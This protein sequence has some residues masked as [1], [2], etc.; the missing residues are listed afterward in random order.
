VDRTIFFPLASKNQIARMFKKFY[1]NEDALAEKFADSIGEARV[2]MAQLQGHFLCA[3][4]DPLKAYSEVSKLHE[5][6]QKEEEAE[7]K[8]KEEE[9]KERQEEREKEEEKKREKEKQ[10]EKAKEKEKEK[11]KIVQPTVNHVQNGKESNGAE[12]EKPLQNGKETNGVETN[13]VDK[14]SQKKQ[15][16]KLKE[17]QDP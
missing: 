10:K 2:S 12:T 13:G 11:E 4:Q 7:K 8:K 6:L 5:Q 3:K 14:P 9:E 16:D 1:P 15:K 17:Q